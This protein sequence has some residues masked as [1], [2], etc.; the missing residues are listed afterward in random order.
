MFWRMLA[1][2]ILA[3]AAMLMA[4]A[5]QPSNHPSSEQ[6]RFLVTCI[7][8]MRTA[9]APSMPIIANGLVDLAAK[10]VAGFGVGSASILFLTDALI[11]FGSPAGDG[12][13]H[14]EG[15][16]D[17]HNGKARI[18][19]RTANDPAHELIAMELDCRP[20]PSIS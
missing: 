3:L 20:A 16:L 9:G 1:K 4:S 11:G 13:E 19:V 7:G 8:T 10:R 15:S 6:Q 17:R 5:S 14:V 12:G 18:V 2:S